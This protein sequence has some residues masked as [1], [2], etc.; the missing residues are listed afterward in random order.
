MSDEQEQIRV[1]LADDHTVV[2]AV[3]PRWFDHR[4]DGP[5]NYEI[6]DA[7]SPHCWF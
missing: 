5:I 6:V 3:S 4:S 2:R 1:L 7:P